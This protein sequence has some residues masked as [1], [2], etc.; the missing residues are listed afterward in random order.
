[1]KQI[2]VQRLAS[3]MRVI[4]SRF[5]QVCRKTFVAELK[6]IMNQPEAERFFQYFCETQKLVPSQR[7]FHFSWT[8]R[9]DF[10]EPDQMRLIINHNF[11]GSSQL[12]SL[13][14]KKSWENRKDPKLQEIDGAKM[15]ENI[16]KAL[17][18][19]S[20]EELSNE[21]SRRKELRDK[22]T[23]LQ[24]ILETADISLEELKTLIATV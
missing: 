12:R 23:K 11:I 20:D 13:Q 1:M 7:R 10:F 16:V 4:Q 21:L 15:V 8:V 18:S 3:R 22:Q 9:Q 6:G 17:S 2:D 5:P 19:F 24:L 14:Q